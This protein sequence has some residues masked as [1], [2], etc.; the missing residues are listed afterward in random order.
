MLTNNSKSQYERSFRKW[1]VSKNVFDEEWNFIFG[2]LDER[3][4]PT[5]V[6]VRGVLIPQATLDRERRRR[7]ET[8][9]NI[10]KSRR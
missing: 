9:F 2:R 4:R 3:R 6:K 5:N 1:N 8:T 10:C 7:R